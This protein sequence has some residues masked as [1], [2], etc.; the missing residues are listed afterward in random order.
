MNRCAPFL[1]APEAQTILGHKQSETPQPRN[2]LYTDLK[3]R[4]RHALPPAGLTAVQ[5]LR[6]S[7]KS[8]GW[9]GQ[10]FNT[11][12]F[13]GTGFTLF[14][15]GFASISAL[16]WGLEVGLVGWQALIQGNLIEHV[17]L[18]FQAIGMGGSDPLPPLPSRFRR[19]Y[20]VTA[21][22]SFLAPY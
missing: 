3:G 22:Y 7:S 17:L 9:E 8:G 14:E 16:I 12:P 18:I 4:R 20:R 5:D 11:R 1:E 2:S 10:A 13:N 19:P 15:A 21:A 6:K